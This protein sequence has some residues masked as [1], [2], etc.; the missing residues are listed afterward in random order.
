MKFRVGQLV[1]LSRVWSRELVGLRGFITHASPGSFSMHCL[2]K[3]PHGHGHGKGYGGNDTDFEAIT[4]LD[5][6]LEALGE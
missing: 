3:P 6:Y 1:R 4:G 5:L 2:G